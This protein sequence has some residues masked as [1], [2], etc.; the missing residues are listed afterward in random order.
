MKLIVSICYVYAMAIGMTSYC[1]IG[2]NLKQ[3]KITQIYSVAMNAITL[4]VLPLAF[5][6]SAQ[7]MTMAEWL[8]SYM[9]ITP[10]VLYSCNY[11]VIAYTLIS[12]CFRD[13]ML[14]DLQLLIMQIK[15]KMSRR[16]KEINPNLRHIFFLK[17]FTFSYLCVAYILTIFVYQWKLEWSQIAYGGLVNTSLTVQIVNTYIYFVSFWQI[18]RGY[19]FVNQQVVEITSAAW[20]GSKVQAVELRGLWALHSNLSRTARRLNRHYGLQM[21]AIRFDYFIFSIINLYMG[22]IYARYGKSDAIEKLYG[23]LIFW[24]RSVDFF[25]ND[26]ICG[27][28]TEYQSQPKYFVNERD[29]SNQLS[30]FLMYDSSTRLDL[31]VCGLYPANK[32]QWMEMVASILV[33]STMLLQFHL[34]GSKK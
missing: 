16:A 32:K 13:A 33:H 5:W 12:R 18:A 28:V 9:W 22:T 29:M 14:L 3:T 19:D 8:P 11:V 24:I 23:S 4:T 15:R 20:L 7:L 26:Y 25:L 30:S 34:V 17:S 6:K 31:K 10:Y 1:L 2:G 27:L 21:L